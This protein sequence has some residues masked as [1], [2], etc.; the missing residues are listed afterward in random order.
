M[1]NIDMSYSRALA[2]GTWVWCDFVDQLAR[3]ADGFCQW[4]GS[5]EHKPEPVLYDQLA[6][7]AQHEA[8]LTAFE[9]PEADPA[10]RDPEEARPSSAVCPIHGAGC[11]AWA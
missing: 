5:T 7:D 2:A 1:S 9:A 11:E 10:E 4:C 6:L 8:E 3:T